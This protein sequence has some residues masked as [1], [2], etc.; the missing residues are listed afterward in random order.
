MRAIEQ[1]MIEARLTSVA[2][3][4]ATGIAGA[5]GDAAEGLCR[6][7]VRSWATGQQPADCHL[8]TQMERCLLLFINCFAATEYAFAQSQPVS[9]NC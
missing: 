9:V 3:Q 6:V 5:K 4:T 8:D 1:G 7:G 2:P